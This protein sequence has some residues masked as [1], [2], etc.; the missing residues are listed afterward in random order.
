MKALFQRIWKRAFVLKRITMRPFYLCLFCVLLLTTACE[1]TLEDK[2]RSQ[3]IE[4]P[5]TL[6]EKE[7]NQILEYAIQQQLE[8]K[9][10][11]SGLFYLIEDPGEGEDHPSKTA[12]VTFYYNC[13]R[14]DGGKCGSSR[15][16]NQVTQLELNSRGMIPGWIEAFQLLK[17]GGRGKFILPSALAYG[18][19]GAG[20]SIPPNTIVVY[21][22]ELISFGE[23]KDITQRQNQVEEAKI[24]D[25]LAEKEWTM[26]RTQSGVYY[27][28]D[29]EGSGEGFPNVRSKV[30]VRYQGTFLDGFTFAE[31]P[32]QGEVVALGSAMGFWKQSI[33]LLKKGG[34]GTFIVPSAMAF[35][36]QEVGSIPPNSVIVAEFELLD[37]E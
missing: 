29:K 30:K 10:T 5:K 22:L 13:E 8:V 3:L 14:L 16:N 28:I 33:P 9:A 1:P 4:S 2:L 7:H 21:D 31:S 18:A 27:R 35:G 37:F 24:R 19:R 32:E 15:D 11:P 20:Q 17:R 12:R 26:K 25:F 23:R 36:N 6:S 34:K